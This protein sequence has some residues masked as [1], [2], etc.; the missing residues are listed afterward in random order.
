M[1]FNEMAVHIAK[2]LE[3]IP[4]NW[5]GKSAIIEMKN[6]GSRHWRQMEWIGFYFEFLCNRHLR[7]TMTDGPKYGRVRFDGFFNVPWDFKAHAQN[8]SSSDII[9]NDLE[10][11]A[12]ALEKYSCVGLIVA[13]GLVHY[14]NEEKSFKRWH[15]ELKGGKSSY[16]KERIRRKATSRRRKTHFRLDEISFVKMD[17]NL[18]E[19]ASTAQKNWRNADGSPRRAK[20]KINL[21]SIESNIV[22]T[23]KY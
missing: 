17:V 7:G 6:E 14:D 13:S 19:K 15:D 3:G 18:V 23:I 1:K 4:N 22:H 20:V 16:E 12:S 21:N 5:D 11:I 9:V 8:A 10:A 2:Y